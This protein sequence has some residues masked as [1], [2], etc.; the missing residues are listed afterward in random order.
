MN[1]LEKLGFVCIKNNDRK[2]I[3]KR[4]GYK[5]IEINKKKRKI[6]V[7]SKFIII[8]NPFNLTPNEMIAVKELMEDLNL[9]E[10]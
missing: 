10:R 1:S 8:D 7:K 2:I 6:Y 9:Y 4:K 3:Y 5:T